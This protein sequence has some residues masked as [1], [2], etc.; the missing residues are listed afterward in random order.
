MLNQFL[1]YSLHIS[2]PCKSLSME[3]TAQ[4]TVELSQS[5]ISD[6]NRRVFSSVASV[7]SS[8][9]GKH[10]G[11]AVFWNLQITRSLSRDDIAERPAQFIEGLRGILG[12][13]ST[14]I[15]ELA[16]TKQL[17]EEFSLVPSDDEEGFVEV[18]SRATRSF[19]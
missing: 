11:E 13:K 3:N 17:Q 14:E 16:M 19:R 15:I 18:V 8:I 1:P 2:R 4:E 12:E 5:I 9:V 10:A 7:L 6:V